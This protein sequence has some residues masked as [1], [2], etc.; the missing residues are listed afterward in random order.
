MKATLTKDEMKSAFREVKDSL[1]L[2]HLE[3]V[4]KEIEKYEPK[5]KET[6]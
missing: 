2:Q 3:I 6:K 4:E 1:S 5:K